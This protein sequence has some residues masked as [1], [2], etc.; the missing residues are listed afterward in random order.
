MP[1]FNLL[2]PWMEMAMAGRYSILSLSLSNPMNPEE[3]IRDIF[4]AE[5]GHPCIKLNSLKCRLFSYYECCSKSCHTDCM[6]FLKSSC[7]ARQTCRAFQMA[8]ISSFFLSFLLSLEHLFLRQCFVLVSQSHSF[9][10]SWKSWSTCD[11]G[12]CIL[13]QCKWCGTA[14]PVSTCVHH[15]PRTAAFNF[16]VQHS[17]VCWTLLC[18]KMCSKDAYIFDWKKLCT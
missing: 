6:P 16:Q 2:L 10:S 14:S 1:L 17:L 11:C 9:D 12:W 5:K 15:H 13:W 3:N 8:R 7:L 18:S 4:L